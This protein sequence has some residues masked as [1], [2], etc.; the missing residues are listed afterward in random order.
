MKRPAQRTCTM[1]CVDA[2]QVDVDECKDLSQ[3]YGVKSMPTFKMLRAGAEVDS[4][5]GADEGAL[6][7]KVVALAG[8]AD[9]WASAGGGRKL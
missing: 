7:E 8:K 9:V 5:N 4:M 1:G 2:A 3:Q 6:R